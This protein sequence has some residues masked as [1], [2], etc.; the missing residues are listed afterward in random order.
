MSGVVAVVKYA[1]RLF[2]KSPGYAAIAIGTLALGIGANTVI[3]SG[4]E[5]MLLRPVPAPHPERIVVLRSALRKTGAQYGVAYP[6]L[7]DW[8]AG[9]PAFEHIAATQIE[10]FNLVGFGNAERVRGARVTS[11]FFEVF[12]LPPSAGRVISEEDDRPGAPPVAVLGYAFAERRFGGAKE[13]LKQTVKIDNV[14]R[15][16]VG[17]MSPYMRFPMGFSDIWVPLAAT[18]ATH[19]RGMHFLLGLGRLRTGSSVADA[20][21]ELDLLSRRIEAEFPDS[22][23]DMGVRVT[24]MIEQITRGPRMALIV[25]WSAVG[26]VLLICCA[27][28][29][30]LSLARAIHRSRE[31]AVRQSVGASR[32][33][34]VRQLLAESVMLSLFGAVAGLVL[35]AWGLDLLSASLPA[36]ML[37]MGGLGL[38]T[39]VLLFTL[40]LSLATGVAFGLAPAIRSLRNHAVEALRDGGRAGI[41]GPVRSRAANALVIGEV[42]LAVT[43]LA[44]AALLISALSRLQ[45]TDLGF[46]PAGVLTAEVAPGEGKSWVID[47]LVLRLNGAP[48]VLSAAATNWLPMTSTSHRMYAIDGRKPSGTRPPITDYRVASPLYSQTMQIR[49]VSGRFFHSGDRHNTEPVAVVNERLARTAWPGRNPVG[50]RIAVYTAPDKV[51]TWRTVVGVVETSDPAGLALTRIPSFICLYRRN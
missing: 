32:W 15:M 49:L 41:G 36:V 39:T 13:A 7:L 5:A 47:E 31:L 24:A 51:G 44:G 3:F 1:L 33:R 16:V 27:N 22:N 34:I 12:G 23:R 17:V 20:T 35:A 25:L 38:N 50:Q 21:R 48:G 10:T 9:A 2:R 29:A 30:N 40:M 18:P 14:P 6:D 42:T 11:Q 26:F 19:G 8:R 28:L 43:L 37:P 4:V 46:Q 45:A